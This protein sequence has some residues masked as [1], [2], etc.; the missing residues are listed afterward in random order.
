MTGTDALRRE[1]R[2]AL[3]SP[4]AR[5]AWQ[6]LS[7]PG[8]WGENDPRPLYRLLGARRLLAPAW[9]D[10][11]GGRGL[12]MS[13][14]AVV[15]QEM[16]AAGIP[17]TL[18]TLSVQICGNFLLGAGTPAQRATLL[19]GLASGHCYCT[20]LY[21]EAGAGSDLAALETR[22]TPENG[23]SWRITGR[24]LYSVRTALADVGLL[25]AR[26]AADGARYR[27]LTLFLVPLTASGVTVTRLPSLSDEAF[28][29]VRLDGVLVGADA[30]V[31][32]AGNAWPL[33]TEALALERTGVDHAAKAAAWLSAA[34][35]A[36]GREAAT[37]GGED[38]WHERA[39][40]LRTRTAAA[41]TMSLRCAA[42][43]GHGGLSPALAAATKLWCSETARSVADWAMLTLGGAALWP[44]GDPD[45]IAAGRLEAAYREAPG[46]VISAGTSEMMRDLV[47]GAGLTAAL[48]AT[49]SGTAGT[50]PDDGLLSELA[51]AVR[52]AAWAGDRD[53]AARG[54]LAGLGLI[55]LGIDP[56]AG[57]LGL[58]HLALA[59]ACGEL[60]ACGFDAGLLDTL[61]AAAALV[62]LG[63]AGEVSETDGSGRRV[64][65]DLAREFLPALLE[66]R[67]RAALVLPGQPARPIAD[68]GPDGLIVVLD[69]WQR[70]LGRVPRPAYPAGGPAGATAFVV[71]PA[72]APGVTRRTRRTMAGDVVTVDLAPGTGWPAARCPS[73][74]GRAVLA[75][76][77]LRRAAWLIGAGTACLADTEQHARTRRQFGRT[78]L[79][80]QAIAHRL[81]D[82]AVTGEA[83]RT[84][85]HD[86]ASRADDTE[87]AAPAREAGRLT[88]AA[89][90]GLLAEAGRFATAAAAAGVHI[91][92]AAGMLAGSPAERAL[93]AVTLAV[94][95]S[96]PAAALDR[97]AAAEIAEEA[98]KR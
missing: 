26:T 36:A 64:P 50:G 18:H 46:L 43:L 24:K 48:A 58:G 75:A 19:P 55:K 54:E 77:L 5:H 42:G 82:L 35:T 40:Q 49:P 34:V 85:L 3:S 1:V 30:V 92:G 78:L 10:A 27:G 96:P 84:L 57:G 20:V 95:A 74:A 33:I 70:L 94:A 47:A 16:I 41:E 44:A 61:T 32:E 31:G 87:A 8:P 88:L 14:A 45:A 83:L 59:V 89:C 91:R 97:L 29:E 86:Q 53:P 79:D 62:A 6:A 13:S 52:S 22:A 69:G 12:P 73:E 66:G 71:V 63:E 7:R 67:A 38:G 25:A 80:N 15:A 81:A 11:F 60:G 72:A 39:G 17:D 2:S 93:R 90:A 98:A 9:P 76:D 51:A 37:A 68:P 65:G 56:A 23:G 4:P 28:A 21:T